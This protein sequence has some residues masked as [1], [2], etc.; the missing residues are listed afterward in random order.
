MMWAMSPRNRRQIFYQMLML[1]LA[2]V[3]EIRLFGLGD[4]LL[5]RMRR[6]TVAINQA[7]ERS[8]ARS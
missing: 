5:G 1:D 8:I 4:F 6:E 3:K 2:A 7:E